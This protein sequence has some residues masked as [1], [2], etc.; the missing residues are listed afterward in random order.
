MAFWRGATT[1]L[2]RHSIPA[3]SMQEIVEFYSQAPRYILCH[4]STQRP[5]LVDA[6]F[7][8][9][10]APAPYLIEFVKPLMKAG[11]SPEAHLDYA[12]LP[13]LDGWSSCSSFRWPSAK[14]G[15]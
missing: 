8:V 5:D 6:G 1:D 13:T 9:I 14:R 11:M 4:L 7:T 15:G 12:Y 3:Y 10:H 2:K